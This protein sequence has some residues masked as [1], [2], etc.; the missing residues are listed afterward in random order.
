[1]SKQLD[2]EFREC[3]KGQRYV[4]DGQRPL[5]QQLLSAGL[6]PEGKSASSRNMEVPPGTEQGSSEGCQR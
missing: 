1:M 3:S 2:G 5:T 4:I 6:E